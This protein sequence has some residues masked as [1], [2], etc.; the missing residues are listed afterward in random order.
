MD[1][2]LA[3]ELTD[4]TAAPLPTDDVTV[5]LPKRPEPI[6]AGSMLAGLI[7]DISKAHT[8]HLA[9]EWTGGI[10]CGIHLLDTTL[11]GFRPASVSYL[12]APPNVGKSTLANQIAYQVAAFPGQSAAA[13]YIS[14]ENPPENLLIKQ[15]AR[16]SGWT[17]TD[18]DTGVID[19]KDKHFEGAITAL[20]TAPI[21]YMAG[22]KNVS[23]GDIRRATETVKTES[24]AEYVF[25]IIDYLQY[26]AKASTDKE[27][28]YE[29]VN[30][31][32]V[33]MR[34]LAN[35]TK[36]HVMVISSQ[37]R[38]ENL[39]PDAGKGMHGATGSG[40]VEYDADLMLTLAPKSENDH[41]HLFLTA[42]KTR[43]G[44]KHKSA[45]LIFDEDRASFAVEGDPE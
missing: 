12:L 25:C 18:I 29:Q 27:S 20:S 5:E 2:T 19:T 38:A 30:E 44:G 13:F 24:G 3:D 22:G 8:K 21:Y 14:Y 35:L 28:R 6:S 34:E 36:C 33:C 10:R 9:G 1:I 26:F 7:A 31:A 15:I 45:A 42:T 39:K 16:L 11:R 40:D 37:N 43:Y 17:Q 32:V 4:T 41:K 23:F